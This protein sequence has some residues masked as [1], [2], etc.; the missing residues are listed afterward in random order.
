MGSDDHGCLGVVDVLYQRG[1]QVSGRLPGQADRSA[2]R[3]VSA[4]AR[5]KG[6]GP[7][8]RAAPVHRRSPRATFPP[9]PRGR[10]VR[11]TS[12]PASVATSWLPPASSTGKAMFSA[13]VS[14]G[15]R[16][17]PPERRWPP[18]LDAAPSGSPS[19]GQQM[20][21]SVG[22]SMAAIRCSS[23][24]LPLPD[25][26]DQCDVVAFGHH[27]AGLGDRGHGAV[28]PGE[29]PGPHD[30]RHSSATLPST[31]WMTR[32]GRRLRAIAAMRHD[33]HC[34][35]VGGTP[36]AAGRALGSAPARRPRPS[37]RQPAAQPGHWRAR[38]RVPPAP[39]RHRTGCLAWRGLGRRVR[40][41]RAASLPGRGVP[42]FTRPCATWMFWVT[43]R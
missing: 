41:Q 30:G 36:S 5:R 17:G 22:W 43:L 15:S 3:P 8:R 24:L 38:R 6:R 9:P 18:C 14:G 23:V 2:R 13:T 37:A 34:L 39:P 27:E 21:P 20:V 12:P 32:S 4:G 35:A 11:S 31:M 19:A 40:C 1:H 33:Q 26:R 16:L 28:D 10:A 42:F 7:A 29:S 25:G